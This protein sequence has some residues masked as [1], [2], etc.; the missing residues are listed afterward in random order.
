VDARA[1]DQAPKQIGFT[2]G[3]DRLQTGESRQMVDAVQDGGAGRAVR[4]CWNIRAPS[5]N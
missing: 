4:N 5:S 1:A 3:S 2:L